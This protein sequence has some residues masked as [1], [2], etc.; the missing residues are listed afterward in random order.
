LSEI[1]VPGSPTKSADFVWSGPVGSGRARVVEFSY[2][3]S[4]TE[5]PQMRISNRIELTVN[6][7]PRNSYPS[8]GD[9]VVKVNGGASRGPSALPDAVGELST[10]PGRELDVVGAASPLVPWRRR[11]GPGASRCVSGGGPWVGAVALRRQT[12]A[13]RL[14]KRVNQT[15][16]AE[17]IGERLLAVTCRQQRGRSHSIK[18]NQIYLRQ[19]S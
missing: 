10:E 1:R 19:I 9:A 14:G 11:V 2:D 5:P 3:H 17:C 6:R 8:S 7:T 15:G 4:A 13:A 18:S 16:R 12:G